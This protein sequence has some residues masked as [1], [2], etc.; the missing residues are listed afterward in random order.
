MGINKFPDHNDSHELIRFLIA[1]VLSVFIHVALFSFVPKEVKKQD[2]PLS[3]KVVYS[4]KK[5]K[6]AAKSAAV[7]KVPP[8]P[9]KKI[10]TP[11]MKPAAVKPVVTPPKKDK[12]PSKP[13][14]I[15]PQ[16]TPEPPRDEPVNVDEEL[17]KSEDAEAVADSSGQD[18]SG[19]FGDS[20][21]NGDG[22]GKENEKPRKEQLGDN[23]L[24]ILPLQHAE[25]TAEKALE[26][27]DEL[28]DDEKKRAY[29]LEFEF[30]LNL[31]SG[32]PENVNQ[33]KKSGLEEL[34]A[35]VK[36]VV[37][38]MSFNSSNPSEKHFLPVVIL[39]KQNASVEPGAVQ[40]GEN[41]PA[42]I[43]GE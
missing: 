30:T 3:F 12:P 43:P 6:A 7:K 9:E 11:V 20:A 8:K 21:G 32:I 23:R 42:V 34:D 38:L 16:P 4:G 33:I 19:E 10:V 36:G 18:S 40:G 27:C 39:L 13:V 35:T 22:A 2:K 26:M 5:A 24:F 14:N 17:G 15:V 25:I 1:I 29:V 41:N 31:E 28:T 37:S